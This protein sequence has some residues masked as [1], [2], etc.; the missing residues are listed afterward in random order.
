MDTPPSVSNMKIKDS[1]M[2]LK[3]TKPEAFVQNKRDDGKTS[4]VILYDSKPN[5]PPNLDC[6]GDEEDL[7][8]SC[9]Y[10]PFGEC[11]AGD[12]DTVLFDSVWHEKAKGW[13]MLSAYT[14]DKNTPCRQVFTSTDKDYC[15]PGS[16]AGMSITGGIVYKKEDMDGSED[17]LGPGKSGQEVGKDETGRFKV[18]RATLYTAQHK[19]GT[20]Y[21]VRMKS[22]LGEQYHKKKFILAHGFPKGNRWGDKD[23]GED[24]QEEKRLEDESTGEILQRD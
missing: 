17:D 18:H 4:Q 10:L 24:Q 11:C 2:P 13:K 6:T 9:D 22:K 8:V 20:F 7:G 23:H 1:V 12:E 15:L 16:T 14:G 5:D 3:A 19:N 21:H